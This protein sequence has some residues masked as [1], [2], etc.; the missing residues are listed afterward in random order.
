MHI[1]SP[2]PPYIFGPNGEHTIPGDSINSSPW[3]ERNAHVNQVK[4]VNKNLIELIPKLLDS[5][6][7]PIIIFARRYWFLVLRLIGNHRQMH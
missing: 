5:E 3:N 2:H 4:F 6:N 1:L 7:K